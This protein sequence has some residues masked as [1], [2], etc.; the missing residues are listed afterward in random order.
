M[1]GFLGAV[2][3]ATVRTVLC[4]HCRRL[5]AIARGSMPFAEACRHCRHLCRV[6]ER[7]AV[8]IWVD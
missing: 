6:T 1:L 3:A 8:A 4:T 2:W 5:R 7:G